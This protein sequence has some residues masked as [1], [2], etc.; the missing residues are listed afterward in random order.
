VQEKVG[1]M[2]GDEIEGVLNH[3]F[4]SFEGIPGALGKDMEVVELGERFTRRLGSFECGM[5]PY[6]LSLAREWIYIL[7]S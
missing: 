1:W 3:R 6:N 5:R 7:G 4:M 2:K